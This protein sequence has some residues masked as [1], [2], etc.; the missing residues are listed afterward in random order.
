MPFLISLL[1]MN[2]YLAVGFLDLGELVLVDVSL[3]DVVDE[4]LVF[5]KVFLVFV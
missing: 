3:L 5:H 2:D 1:L 4:A